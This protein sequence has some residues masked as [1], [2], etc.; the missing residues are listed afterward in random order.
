MGT[1]GLAVVDRYACSLLPSMLESIEG[2]INGLSYIIARLIEGYPYN[3]AGI[4]QLYA[5]SSPPFSSIW[6]FS[7]LQN[8]QTHIERTLFS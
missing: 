4:V 3:A 5:S 8:G 7:A 2:I 6:R 1:N